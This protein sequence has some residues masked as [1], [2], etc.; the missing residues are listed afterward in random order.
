MGGKP[1]PFRAEMGPPVGQG[2]VVGKVLLCSDVGPA[3]GLGDAAMAT[4][5]ATEAI[6]RAS[7]RVSG[8]EYSHHVYNPFC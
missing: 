7:V 6:R 2:W 4:E 3:R 5:D 1:V 8:S